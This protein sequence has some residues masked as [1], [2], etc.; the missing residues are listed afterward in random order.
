MRRKR[1]PWI[2]RLPPGVINNPAWI[3]IGALFVLAGIGVLAGATSDTSISQRLE[4][5]VR[6]AWGLALFVGGLLMVVTTIHPD[7]LLER[8]VLRVLSIIFITYA[9]W[10]VAVVGAR[11]IITAVMCLVLVA[12]FEVRIA[13]IRQILSPWKSPE[14]GNNG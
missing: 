4:P 10:A 12:V 13:V 5:F 6:Q 2:L 7:L 9:G 11:A 3:F 8:F 14:V 1:K